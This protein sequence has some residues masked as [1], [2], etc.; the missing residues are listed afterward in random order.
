MPGRPHMP[1]NLKV[2]RGTFRKDR[3]HSAEPQPEAAMPTCPSFLSKEAKKEWR[4]LSGELYI[5][6]LLT[7]LDR[8][9]LA[10]YCAAYA[11]WAEAEAHLT[12]GKLTT[13]ASS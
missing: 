6:G 10:G 13:V 8:A 3:V 11:R 2:L 9:A 5:L 4:R 7:R 12:G 1:T